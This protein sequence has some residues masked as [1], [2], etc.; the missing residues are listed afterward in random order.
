ML[1]RFIAKNIRDVFL[2]NTVHERIKQTYMAEIDTS[3]VRLTHVYHN[4]T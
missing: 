3:V 2:R 4:K 1:S